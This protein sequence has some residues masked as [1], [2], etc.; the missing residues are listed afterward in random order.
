MTG[1]SINYQSRK[2]Q[3]S[4]LQEKKKDIFNWADQMYTAGALYKNS[5][6]IILNISLN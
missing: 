4:F 1:H 3:A 5:R 2:K 6:I